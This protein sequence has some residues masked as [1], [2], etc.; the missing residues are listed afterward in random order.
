MMPG[1]NHP[2]SNCIFSNNSPTMWNPLNAA[3]TRLNLLL[4]SRRRASAPDSCVSNYFIARLHALCCDFN[5]CRCSARGGRRQL[6]RAAQTFFPN[7]HTI[8]MDVTR[9]CRTMEFTRCSRTWLEREHGTRRLNYI[10]FLVRAWIILLM[11][12]FWS[13]NGIFRSARPSMGAPTTWLSL[14]N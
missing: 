5:S 2:V 13:E 3:Q 8:G 10:N 14:I 12:I 11:S 7:S 6:A 1:T 9:D 4:Y